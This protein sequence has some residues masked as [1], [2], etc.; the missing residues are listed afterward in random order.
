MNPAEIH[1]IVNKFLFIL[2]LFT[3]TSTL[4]D[5]NC[6]RSPFQESSFSLKLQASLIAQLVKSQP[7]SREDPLEKGQAMHSNIPGLPLWI[8]Q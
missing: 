1:F 3:N 4:P 7:A 6:N 2:T 8:S 5:F